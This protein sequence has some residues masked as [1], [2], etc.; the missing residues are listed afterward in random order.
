M[1]ILGERIST[2]CMDSSNQ[3]PLPNPVCQQHQTTPARLEVGASQAPKLAALQRNT[4]A[5][6]FLREAQ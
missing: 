6:A 4:D 2:P 3:S 1:L 5:I